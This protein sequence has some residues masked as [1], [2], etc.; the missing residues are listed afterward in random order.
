[1]KKINDSVFF[2]GIADRERKLFD[3]LVPLREGTT[4]NSYLV[5]GGEKNALIDTMYAPFAKEYLDD[6]KSAG[7]KIDYIVSNHAE[8]DHSSLIPA[9]LEIYPDAV[10]LC[11]LKGA[12]NLKN[13][14]NVDS[15][16]IRVVSDNE[17][18]S[19]GGKTLRFYM[20]AFV[21]W[22][23]TMFTYLVEDNLLFTCDFF[24]AHYT[25]FDLYADNSP[26]LELAAKS[27]YAEIMMPFA[28]FCR[29]HLA[30]AKKIN[31]AMVLP[32][33]GAVYK[34]PKFI[35][36]LYEKWT[37]TEVSGKVLICYV[38]MYGNTKILAERLLNSLSKLGISAKAVD[39]MET[40]EG[41]LAEELID[42]TGVVFGSSCILS[43]PHPRLVYCAYLMSILKPK[44]KFYTL[45]G[46]IGWGG[47]LVAPIE[48]NL[49]LPSIEKLDPFVIKGCPKPRD[50]EALE[51]FARA[52][53]DKVAELKSA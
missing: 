17:E 43:G 31:P 20:T 4:Y 12:E 19:L 52:I 26:A 30:L 9:L 29:K 38:S 8:Q 48:A 18:V 45:I 53:A 46:S 36:E 16:K 51:A 50:F 41:E 21:H 42:A 34:D 27:Y 25:S 28:S 1:M 24:G 39:L 5:K 40:D 32:S 35:F 44:T 37:S 33:H 2:L 7:V 15:S 49:K 47:N 14:L 10:V 6:V 11:S 22:P 3:Q 13:M 23:D